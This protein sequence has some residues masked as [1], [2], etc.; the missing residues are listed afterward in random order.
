MIPF[1]NRNDDKW[2][3]T[4][5]NK[6]VMAQIKLEHPMIWAAING[7]KDTLMIKLDEKSSVDESKLVKIEAELCKVHADFKC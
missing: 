7:I 3:H 2:P 4:R 1:L 6:D 5:A